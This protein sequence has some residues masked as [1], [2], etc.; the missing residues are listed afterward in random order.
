M[1]VSRGER[2]N[3]RKPPHPFKA[4]NERTV[5]TKRKTRNGQKEL[6]GRLGKTQRKGARSPCEK[7]VRCLRMTGPRNAARSPKKKPCEKG[8]G[9]KMTTRPRAMGGNEN[10]NKCQNEGQ[11]SRGESGVGGVGDLQVEG[12]GLKKKGKSAPQIDGNHRPPPPCKTIATQKK[13]EKRAAQGT[14]GK[15]RGE[16]D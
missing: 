4:S 9:K 13:R 10:A 7:L 14:G 3:R 2:K 6:G 16:S 5:I 11:G 12:P 15:G 8:G 1:K